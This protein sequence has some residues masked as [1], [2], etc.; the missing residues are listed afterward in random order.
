MLSNGAL[1][2]V[3]SL[4]RYSVYERNDGDEVYIRHGFPRVFLVEYDRDWMLEQWARQQAGT[5]YERRRNRVA[6]PD[7]LREHVVDPDVV[8]DIR[9]CERCLDPDEESSGQSV[10]HYSDG[11]ACNF[12]VDEHYRQCYDCD[13]LVSDFSF[14]NGDD[15]VCRRCLD[16]NYGYCDECETYYHHDSS[17]HDHDDSDCDCSPPV[18]GFAMP[19]GDETLRNDTRI[20]VSLPAGFLDDEGVGRVKDYLRREGEYDAARLVE[21]L[22]REWQTSEGNLTKRLSRALYKHNG[23]KL[24]PTMLSAVGNI[25]SEHSR[26]SD[27]HIEITRDLNMSPGD[28]AHEGSCWWGE[29][30]AGR[31]ALKTNGGFGLRTFHAEYDDVAGRAWVMPLRVTPTGNLI[32]TFDAEGA[33]AFV[34]FNGYGELEGYNPARIVAHLAGMTYRKIGFSASHMWVNNDSAYLVG[35][36]DIVQPH[37][38]GSLR[39]SLEQ[40]ADLYDAER[41]RELVDA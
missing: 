16:N 4:D 12:C 27:F 36:E 38:D 6:F 21:G 29:Y 41:S 15:C 3:E 17:D 30:N 40:H 33:D 26:G 14:V 1:R 25:A 11:W 39:L 18:I 32:P 24:T 34:V 10:G 20:R 35:S 13:D 5:H 37:T 22:G 9:F 31:C 28:F 19:N 23:G 7:W 2:F 8:D